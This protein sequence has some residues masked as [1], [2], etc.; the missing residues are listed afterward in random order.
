MKFLDFFHDKAGWPFVAGHVSR[1]GIIALGRMLGLCLLLLAAF[2]TPVHGQE[3]TPKSTANANLEVPNFV[4]PNTRF[5]QPDTARI[6]RLRFLTTTDF[7]PFNFIDRKGRL[8]GFHVDLA[9]AIC[10]KLDITPRCQIQALP[11]EDLMPVLERGDAEALIA[12][13]AISEKAREKVSFSSIYMKIPARFVTRNSTPMEEPMFNALFRKT[14]GVVAGSAH[15]AYFK[16]A[17]GGRQTKAYPSRQQ[18]LEA[19]KKG[20]VDAGFS[21]AVSIGF[22]LGSQGSQNCCSFAGGPYLSDKYFGLGMAI[23]LPKNNFNLEQAVNYALKS[24]NDS[25][26]LAELYLRY[27]PLGL[28]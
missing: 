22:W 12:G 8:T 17:F 6:G 1:A 23:A 26:K 24:I 14:T 10:E 28:Y 5:G 3:T 9:R 13:N 20:E 4:D 18:L 2:Q 11:F 25:G 27:F 16:Q 15:E 21:D 7:P 19:V